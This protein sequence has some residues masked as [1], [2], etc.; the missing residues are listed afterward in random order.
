MKKETLFKRLFDLEIIVHSTDIQNYIK[1]VDMAYN[2][3][4][5]LLMKGGLYK[6]YLLYIKNKV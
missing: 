3:Y 5:R 6:E 1:E 4:L 2:H